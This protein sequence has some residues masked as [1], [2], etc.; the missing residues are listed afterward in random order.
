MVLHLIDS[1]G[2]YGAEKV[3]LSL[4]EELRGSDCPG[5]LGCLC[6]QGEDIPVIAKRC[7]ELGVEVQLFPMRRGIDFSGIIQIMRYV[8]KT[9]T[10]IVHTHGYK[11]NILM[12]LLP[13]RLCKRVATV[14]GWAKGTGSYLVRLYELLDSLALKRADYIIAVSYGVKSDLLGKGFSSEEIHVIHNGIKFR[15]RTHNGVER[16]E[17]RRLLGLKEEHLV[18]A[19]VGRL[20]PIKGHGNLIEAFFK[21]LSLIRPAVLIIAGEGP[22]RG[23]L[24]QM[25]KRLGL[26]ESVRLPGFI[27]DIPN[28][29]EAIDI[30]VMP[31]Y[32]EGMPIALLEAMM[33]EKPVIA[34]NVGGIPEVIS[35]SDV[36]VLISPDNIPELTD[37]IIALGTDA[38]RRARVGQVGRQVIGKRFSSQS[39]ARSYRAVYKM[40]VV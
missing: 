4:L 29:L 40:C 36:G 8:K 34:T 12:S 19:A 35:G 16:Q 10:S 15:P 39:M 37:A 1:A 31:S 23:S 5:V 18:V 30:F 27:E 32:S 7:K 13:K 3:T 33:E 21:S 6:V 22:L 11:P 17:A 24:E 2:L 28:F 14:H 38:V 25:V 9:K 26:E 20:S